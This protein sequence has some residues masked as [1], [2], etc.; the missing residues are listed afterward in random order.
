MCLSLSLLVNWCLSYTV[1]INNDTKKLQ[2]YEEHLKSIEDDIVYLFETDRIENPRTDKLSLLEEKY[3]NA[4]YYHCGIIGVIGD[5]VEV[6]KASVFFGIFTGIAIYM[7]KNATKLLK[8]ILGYIV[9]AVLVFIANEIMLYM[10][11]FIEISIDG[12]SIYGDS[13][14]CWNMDDAVAIYTGITIVLT[15]IRFIK[16]RYTAK[17]LNDL[18]K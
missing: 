9:V 15:V 11:S 2:E 7:Y 13:G 14:G 16:N 12:S 3:P 6:V 5:F 17:N 18:I 10:P 8:L 1:K 4:M